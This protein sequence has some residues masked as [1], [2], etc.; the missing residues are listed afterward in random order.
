[1]PVVENKVVP[2]DKSFDKLDGSEENKEKKINSKKAEDAE[3]TGSGSSKLKSNASL[4]LQFDFK[5]EFVSF[6]NKCTYDNAKLALI[7]LMDTAN[8]KFSISVYISQIFIL[9]ML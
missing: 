9:K 5:D 6:Y 1:M 8:I 2:L 4:K 3:V 7:W